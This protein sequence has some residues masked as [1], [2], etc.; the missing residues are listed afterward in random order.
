MLQATEATERTILSV[1]E[2]RPNLYLGLG[3]AMV[4]AGV[5]AIV[6]PW[7]ATL[8][9][10]ALLGAILVVGGVAAGVHGVSA[11]RGNGVALHLVGAALYVVVGALLL[12]FPVAGVVAL[13]LVIGAFFLAEG[14]LR[15]VQAV[16]LRGRPGVGWLAAGGVLALV[17][18]VLILAAWPFSAAWTLG[19]LLG[20]DLIFGGWWLGSLARTARHR[21]APARGEHGPAAG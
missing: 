14:V 19:I 2:E 17:L 13:T 16:R 4:V 3:I 1:I 6:L 9:A 20:I 7:L 8:A 5:A 11:R 15:L 18:A 21:Q 10:E 12:L